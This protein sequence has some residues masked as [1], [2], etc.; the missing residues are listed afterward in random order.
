MTGELTARAL[1]TLA[2]CGVKSVI[3]LCG[4]WLVARLL[5]RSAAVRHLV[6][7]AAFVILL[8]LPPLSYFAPSYGVARFVT[9]AQESDPYEA[10]PGR[11]ALILIKSSYREEPPDPSRTARD[12]DGYLMT[13]AFALWLSGA[14]LITL[15][16]AFAYSTILSLRRHSSPTAPRRIA[17]ARLATRVGLKGR[18]ELRTSVHALPATAMTW[19]LFRPVVLLPQGSAGW[20]EQWLEA[21]L[22]HELAHVRRRDGVTQLLV[23]FVCAV[24][25]F[26]PLVWVAARAVRAEAERAADDLVINSGVRPSTYA[27]GLLELAASGAGHRQ[28]P[29][30]YVLSILG[31]SPIESR[32]SAIIEP[33]QHRRGANSIEG[34]TALA[35]GLL[36]LLLFVPYRSIG[37]ASGKRGAAAAAVR[38]DVSRGGSIS[39]RADSQDKDIQTQPARPA[40]VAREVAQPPADISMRASPQR[41]SARTRETGRESDNMIEGAADA[42]EAGVSNPD[43]LAEL[44]RGDAT[45]ARAAG[46][47]DANV[48][49]I[50]VEESGGADIIAAD[51]TFSTEEEQRLRRSGNADMVRQGAQPPSAERHGARTQHLSADVIPRSP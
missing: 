50:R 32:I 14:A 8:L 30:G 10:R 26:N 6:W 47:A 34:S 22:L 42:R 48:N 18:W 23:E 28:P 7:Q 5:R 49:Q 43:R 39:E 37:L 36:T 12:L 41:S 4:A 35:A 9:G 24:Y 13:I 25:W 29:F 31:G 11:T 51:S 2:D 46:H 27:A 21:V 38:Q 3:I 40:S 15:R 33:N 45:S 1:T 44:P 16:L 20:S 17:P 19:G